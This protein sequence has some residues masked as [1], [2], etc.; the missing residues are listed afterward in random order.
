MSCNIWIAYKLRDGRPV[1]ELAFATR[2]S[3]NRWCA[4][5][6][7]GTWSIRS[8]PIPQSDPLTELISAA[9]SYAFEIERID[10]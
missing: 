1:E 5:N 2:K 8:I 7:P 3:A 9:E 4:M 10:L 6:G